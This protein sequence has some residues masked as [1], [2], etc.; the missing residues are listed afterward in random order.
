[1]GSESGTRR[2]V[3]VERG[4]YRQANEHP[5]PQD[6]QVGKLCRGR[7]LGIQTR[8]LH[9]CVGLHAR[10]LTGSRNGAP[11][12]RVWGASSSCGCSAGS[13]DY[14]PRAQSARRPPRGKEKSAAKAV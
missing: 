1:M 5:Q 7:R 14:C 12:P 13:A 8:K 10:D 9:G 3:R 4:I 6:D 11:H 2:R